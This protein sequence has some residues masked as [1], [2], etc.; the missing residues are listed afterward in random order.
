M[1]DDTEV[2]NGLIAKLRAFVST[3]LDDQE[4]EMFAC[5]LAP[6]VSLAYDEAEGPLAAEV[7]GFSMSGTT[8]AEDVQWRP[9]ALARALRGPLRDRGLRVVGLER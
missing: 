9:D 2:A 8:D 1:R 5:L 7:V 3:E 6:G 4:N